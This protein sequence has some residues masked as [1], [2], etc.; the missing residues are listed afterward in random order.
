MVEP[1]LGRMKRPHALSRCRAGQQN[2]L[3]S[4]A[5]QRK[6]QVSTSWDLP[7]YY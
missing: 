1:H 2:C 4:T 7:L 6:L 3:V 5:N